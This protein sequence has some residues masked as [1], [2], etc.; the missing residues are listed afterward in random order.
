MLQNHFIVYK[1][2]MRYGNLTMNKKTSNQNIEIVAFD[3]V[4]FGLLLVISPFLLFKIGDSIYYG[5]VHYYD[6]SIVFN[7]ALSALFFLIIFVPLVVIGALRNRMT[8]SDN[9][10]YIYSRLSTL[11]PQKIIPYP[12]IKKIT[13]KRKGMHIKSDVWWFGNGYFYIRSD[14]KKLMCGIERYENWKKMNRIKPE[15]QNF[16]HISR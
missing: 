6:I 5:I 3:S 8:F 10:I 11:I 7:A 2:R 4:L 9:Y 13:L 1:E 14:V 12:R 16:K 15:F